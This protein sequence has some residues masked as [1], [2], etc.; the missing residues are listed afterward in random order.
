MGG[1]RG[2]G[3]RARDTGEKLPRPTSRHRRKIY[4]WRDERGRR[5]V[6]LI[7]HALRARPSSCPLFRSPATENFAE[8]KNGIP[9][10]S[11]GTERLYSRRFHEATRP[12]TFATSTSK[13]ATF[14]F[15]FFTFTFTFTGRFRQRGSAGRLDK[16]PDDGSHKRI[17]DPVALL[18]AP[19]Q[20][21]NEK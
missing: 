13:R 8:R 10:G 14:Y 1:A 3:R 2:S 17:I 12:Q 19:S 16:K 18:S 9:A 21:D 11:G 7:S 20:C 6:P 15:Y 4:R 5:R